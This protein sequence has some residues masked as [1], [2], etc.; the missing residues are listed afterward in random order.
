MKRLV[1]AFAVIIA[2]AVP[3]YVHAQES[4]ALSCTT[5]TPDPAA[6][7][8]V[9][10]QPHIVPGRI[11][12]T[13][14]GRIANGSGRPASGFITVTLFDDAANIVGVYS[15]A[16]RNVAANDEVTYTAIGT[17]LPQSWATAEAKVSQL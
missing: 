2:A 6:G 13:V 5:A 16:V 12:M 10:G 8:Q 9:V 4:P 11:G 15:G 7:L 1:V 17:D 14:N 3:M